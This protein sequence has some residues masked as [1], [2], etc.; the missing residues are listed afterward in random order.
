MR[1]QWTVGLVALGAAVALACG[2]GNEDATGGEPPPEPATTTAAATT[3]KKAGPLTQVGNGTYTVGTDMAAG[4]YKVTGEL[5][6]DMNCFWS[7]YVTGSNGHDIVANDLPTGGW[8]QITVKKGQDFDSR[9]CGTWKK[10][11]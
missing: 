3:T 4:T 6:A 8:P 11:K 1:T 7:I 5:T 9:G 2:S 10:I